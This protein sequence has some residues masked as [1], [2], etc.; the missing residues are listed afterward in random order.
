M[1]FDFCKLF[2]DVFRPQSNERVTF[3]LDMPCGNIKDTPKWADRRKLA[4]EWK[5][6]LE[7]TAMK[8]QI[9]INPIVSYHATGKHNADLPETA[10]I[11]GKNV[12][13]SESILNSDII[14]AM[15]E[16]SPSAP[17]LKYA[18]KAKSLR[19]ASMPG[20]ERRMQET[21]LAADY[22]IVAKRCDLVELKLK[23][24]IAGEVEFS[25]GHCCH[26]D[27]RFNEVLK[28]DGRLD[29]K[30]IKNKTNPLCNL[31]SGEVFK[32]PYE[33]EKD[34]IPSETKGELPLML[35]GELAVF[36]V[37]KNK[38]VEVS[39]HGQKVVTMRKYLDVDDARKN[40]AEFGIGCNDKA[41]VCGNNLE[42]EKVLGFHWAHGRSDHLGG[43]TGVAN[44][45]SPDNVIHD[46]HAYAK[47]MPIFIKKLTLISA[48]G[49]KEEII[50]DGDFLVTLL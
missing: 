17:L 42:D 33:G 5:E 34:D 8:W 40:I 49:S 48:T 15:P 12:S 43:V 3:L 24:A 25:T 46:D 35:D 26:F 28:D 38:V 27:L 20:V 23:K 11:N 1:S 4:V 16:F 30:S 9:I 31:P 50:K 37:L 47:G 22:T 2:Y 14:V 13:F 6:A 32:A 44:F 10:F 7:K 21:A 19:I 39:G 45:K 29:L 41:K 18:K 36:R